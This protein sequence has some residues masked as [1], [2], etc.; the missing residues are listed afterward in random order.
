MQTIFIKLYK[1]LSNPSAAEYHPDAFNK[2]LAKRWGGACIDFHRTKS[3]ADAEDI[4]DYGTSLF[5]DNTEFFPKKSFDNVELRNQIAK[6]VE[7][8]SVK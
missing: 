3:R 4:E 1:N 6:L 2:F 5:E 8:L 7:A